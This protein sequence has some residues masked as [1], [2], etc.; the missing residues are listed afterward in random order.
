MQILLVENDRDLAELWGEYLR[1][2]GHDAEVANS[3]SHGI[4]KIRARTPELLIVDYSLGDGTASDV[5]DATESLLKAHHTA[6]WACSGHGRDLPEGL[7]EKTTG[8][9]AKP[10]RLDQLDAIVRRLIAARESEPT[11]E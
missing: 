11:G 10:F 3:V 1:A 4:E 7:L 5:I 6:V 2:R 8:V 9:L